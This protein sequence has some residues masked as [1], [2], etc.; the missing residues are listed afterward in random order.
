MVCNYWIIS[1]DV[2]C[3]LC[4]V[5]LGIIEHFSPVFT[6]IVEKN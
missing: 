1:V 4:S 5:P 3:L 6:D 2:N